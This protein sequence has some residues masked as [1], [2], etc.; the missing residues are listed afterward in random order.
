MIDEA[1]QAEWPGRSTTPDQEGGSRA[2]EPEDGLIDGIDGFE[3]IGVLGHGGMGVV[4]KARDR[5]LDR[6]VA[7]KTIPE[8]RLATP[9]QRERFRSEAQAVARLRHPN[10]IAIHAIGEHEKLPYLSLEFAEGGSLADR[11]VQEPL[12]PRE[13]A[14]LVETVARAVH[15]AHQAGVIHRDLKPSNV[16]L[17]ADGVP[18]V[19]DFGLAKLLDVDSGR[20][21]TGEI[22]GTPSFMSPEQAE[23][24]A[25]SVTPSTD[26]YSLGAILYQALSGRP[27]F[28]GETRLETIKLVTSTEAVPPRRLRPDV[29]RDLETICLS[30]LE[31]SAAKRY[32]SALELADD[33]RRFLGGEPI[34][35]RRIGVFRRAAKWGRRHPW[36]S[37]SAAIVL[38]AVVA[39]VGLTY[40]HNLQLRA[41]IR[42]TAAKSAEARGKY[43]QARST[44]QAMVERLRDPRFAGTPRMKELAVVLMED[45]LAFYDRAL[46]LD[47]ANDPSI[48][49]DTARAMGILSTVQHELGRTEQAEA[50][51]RQALDLLEGLRSEY[52]DNPDY[53][54]NQVECFN[55]LAAYLNTSGRAED[56]L[57]AS[58]ESIRLAESLARAT[59]DNPAFSE[60]VAVCHETY[61]GGLRLLGLF[62][63]AGNHYSVAIEIRNRLDPARQPGLSQRQAVTLTND[64]VN[65]WNMR[66]LPDAEARFRQTE[67]LLLAP[68]AAQRDVLGLGRLPMNWSGLL[69]SSNRC[70]EAIERCT[71]GL[72]GIDPYI[73]LEPNDATAVEVCLELHGNLGLA[74]EARQRHAESAAEWARVVELSP[75][76]VPVE[77]RLELAFS[78]V[79]A[80]DRDRALAQAQLASAAPGLAG[81]D[82]YNLA[83]VYSLARPLPGMIEVSRP[84]VES[85]ASRHTSRT[86]CTG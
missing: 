57:S 35:A 20:T 19:S 31:K 77:Y 73:R 3:V 41:E 22:M 11:L 50:Q 62:P 78:L 6:I 64:G 52:P 13:A 56:A 44:I 29:P 69:I 39:L 18:K 46:H 10:I 61:A 65:L 40:R 71:R 58:G 12:P 1:E 54:L 32:A 26:V 66:R 84:T 53:R 25:R 17:T 4:Y 16:L 83:C 82:Y 34:R 28:L 9:D 49:A 67:K 72:E 63:E 74:L 45:A 14:A 37:V 23:G 2:D 47:D 21:M 33:L 86:P 68:P 81:K 70:D 8:G 85:R 24:H 36:Q 60:L 38:I 55:R 76:P 80:G 59:P 51:V 75:S 15:A 30:C 5:E 42:R 27:P 7:I 43:R 79:R 48:R